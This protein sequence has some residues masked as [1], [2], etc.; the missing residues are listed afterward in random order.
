MCT[1]NRYLRLPAS[2]HYA[3]AHCRKNDDSLVAI[4]HGPKI[5][6][7]S[8]MSRGSRLES[9]VLRV[10]CGKMNM[11]FRQCGLMC[12]PQHLIFGVSS[13]GIKSKFTVEIKCPINLILALS[14]K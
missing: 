2:N 4:L 10:V 1:I 9:A 14:I 8:A 3:V 7:T 5:K 12:D 6:Q 11:N 13:D